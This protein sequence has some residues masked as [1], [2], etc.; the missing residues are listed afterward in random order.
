MAEMKKNL[1]AYAGGRVAEPLTVA[2]IGSLDINGTYR[3]LLSTP[4]SYTGYDIVPGKN[5]GGL[6]AEFGIPASDQRFDIVLCGQVLEH[7]RNPHQTVSEMARV[8]KRGGLLFAT[9]PAVFPKHRHPLDCWRI[10]EDGMRALLE[11]H[12]LVVLQCYE[13][14]HEYGTD[15]WGIGMKP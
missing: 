11:L 3:T 2:D 13:R 14:T 5:V 6:M 4:W 12:G 1:D 8:L 7:V 9:V 10:F 15:T